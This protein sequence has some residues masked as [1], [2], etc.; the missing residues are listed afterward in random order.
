M[1][2]CDNSIGPN[3]QDSDRLPLS[4]PARSTFNSHADVP[5]VENM[6]LIHFFTCT[7]TSY[8]KNVHLSPRLDYIRV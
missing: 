6:V 7:S 1:I 2:A 8:A 4:H 5:S 3:G